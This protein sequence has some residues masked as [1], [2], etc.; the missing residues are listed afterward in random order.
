MEEKQ[1]KIKKEAKIKTAESLGT[2]THTHTISLKN[3]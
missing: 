3:C 1:M 2:V